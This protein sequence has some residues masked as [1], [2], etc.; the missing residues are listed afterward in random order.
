M[1]CEDVC[2]RGGGCDRT[3]H[4]RICSWECVCKKV[5]CMLGSALEKIGT[6]RQKQR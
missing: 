3:V 2:L 4:A 1:L 5:V 6:N